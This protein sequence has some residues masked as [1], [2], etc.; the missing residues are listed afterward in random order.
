MGYTPC[1]E[2]PRR[3]DYFPS[4]T[5]T[6]AVLLWPDILLKGRY[7]RR[8]IHIALGTQARSGGAASKTA[9]D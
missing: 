6:A 4:K 8:V 2:E 7:P 1:K 3:A 5:R 9:C